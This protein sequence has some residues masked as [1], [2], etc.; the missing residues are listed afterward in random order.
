MWQR[1][2]LTLFQATRRYV[3]AL[4]CLL[5][6]RAARAVTVSSAGW[7]SAAECAC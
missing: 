5:A 4:L 3:A 2:P 7:R 6:H 1:H